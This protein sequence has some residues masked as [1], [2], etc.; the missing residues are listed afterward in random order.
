MQDYYNK[1]YQ[2]QELDADLRR[3]DRLEFLFS[4]IP[5]GL[6]ILD[7]GC[8]PGVDISFLIESNEV[9]GVDIADEALKIASEQGIIT[10]RLDLSQVKQLPF[11]EESFDI[12]IATDIL[13]H[14]FLP[15]KLLMEIRRLLKTSGLAI[16]SVPNHFYWKMRLRILRGADV[17]LPFHRDA[18]QWEYFHIRFFTS[19]GFE[20]LLGK[21]GFQIATRYYDRFIDVPRGLPRALDRQLAAS[22]PDLFSMHFLVKCRIHRS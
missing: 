9:H 6:Q 22:Y 1:T 20:E 13:E 3:R 8:G 10:H 17:I 21:T 11:S 18:K 14:L 16:L 7:V 12:V 4:Q 2:N 19:Q 15:E 5:S